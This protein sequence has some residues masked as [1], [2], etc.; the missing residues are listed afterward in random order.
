MDIYYFDFYFVCFV[1]DCC[2]FL[3]SI[4]WFIL[5]IEFEL[6]VRV[7]FVKGVRWF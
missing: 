6:V 7:W 5:Y 1:C 2:M 4:F 3:G